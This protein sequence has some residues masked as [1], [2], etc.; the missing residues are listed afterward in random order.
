MTAA[1]CFP[2][3]MEPPLFGVSVSRKRFS[4]GLISKGKAF[5]INTVDA[6]LKDAAVGAG[7]ASGKDGDKF[8]GLGITK[9]YGKLG[10]PLVK[11]SPASIECKVVDEIELGD[12]VLFVGEAVNVIERRKAKG[13]YHAGGDD[14]TEV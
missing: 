14:F 5:A 2:I 8:T 10:L 6:P 13:L 12:H 4:H 9:E 3:S 7:R 11:E 1:W